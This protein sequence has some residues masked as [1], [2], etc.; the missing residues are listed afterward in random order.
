MVETL[1]KACSYFT[2]FSVGI[3]DFT[4]IK[5]SFVV[6]LPEY[7]VLVAARQD[8]QIYLKDPDRVEDP[9]MK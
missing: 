3:R 5:T 9:P 2:F 1:C 4:A 6:L 7:G 8:A